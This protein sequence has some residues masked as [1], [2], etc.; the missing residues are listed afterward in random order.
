MTKGRGTGRSLT[1]QVKKAEERQCET[2]CLN[3]VLN[4]HVRTVK[5]ECP[6]RWKGFTDSDM[7]S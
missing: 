3:K 4:T 7:P 5:V 1:R 6:L 2:F